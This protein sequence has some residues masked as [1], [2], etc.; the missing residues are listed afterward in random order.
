MKRWLV[1]L[2]LTAFLAGCGGEEEKPAA[3]PA[4]PTVVTAPPELLQRLKIG[5]AGE[6]E[7]GDVLRVPAQVAVDGTR[8]ARIGAPVTGRV[9]EILALPGQKVKAGDELASLHSTELSAAQL[10]YL[11][12]ASQQDLQRRAV[13]RAKLLYGADVIGLAE[14]QKR[15][16]ELSQARAEF[17][18]AHD[19]LKALG[20]PPAAVA[21]L[22]RNGNIRSLSTVT[23]TL[24]GTVIERRVTQGQ[25]VQPADVLFT[26][27][28]LGHV[29][30][31]AEVPEQQAEMVKQ[32]EAALAEIPAL[33]GRKIEGK[34]IY[35]AD[36]V[37]PKS[38]TVTVRMD[39]ENPDRGIKPEMLATM[40]IRGKAEKRLAVPAQ[41]VVR[42]EN[43]SFVFVQLDGQRFKLRAVELGPEVDGRVPVL[44]GLQAG[45]KIVADG[46]FHLNNERKRKE[47]EGS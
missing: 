39:V 14:L 16:A 8:Y 47:L 15:E 19:Q 25:V 17:Q 32:G 10:A 11:K 40:L 41:A 12:A 27:A 26:I 18:A 43:K 13:E 46:A 36:T 5:P 28:D 23:A 7:I 22:A 30:I 38:R 9:T 3:A 6:A 1:F 2:M 45:E 4:D 42:E 34:L 35:V 24:N 21:K 29:W 44:K 31:T 20:M 33:P 37:D